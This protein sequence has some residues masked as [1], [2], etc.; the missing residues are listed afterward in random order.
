[1]D[2]KMAPGQRQPLVSMA[3]CRRRDHG[4]SDQRARFP[5]H[6]RLWHIR[7]RGST[8]A[9]L[10]LALPWKYGFK[11]IKSIVRFTFTDKRPKGMWE[12]L[13]TVRVRLLGQRQSAGAASALESGERRNHRHRA[14]AGRR[15]C[16]TATANMSPISTRDWTANASGRD[17]GRRCT[18]TTGESIVRG[19]WKPACGAFP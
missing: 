8:G 18:E 14:S 12:A 16:S 15:S 11:S 7:L 5:R 13:Q 1:M 4:G 19:P 17:P 10:R 2:P 6:R 9:P 3:L